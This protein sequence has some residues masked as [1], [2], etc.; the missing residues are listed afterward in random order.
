M[1]LYKAVSTVLFKCLGEPPKISVV[2]NQKQGYVLKIRKNSAKKCG[3][4]CCI[5]NFSKNC[6]IQVTE[7]ERYLT[8]Q[9]S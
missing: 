4:Y 6:N 1:S 3:H 8:I 2:D 7:D 5:R 9:S